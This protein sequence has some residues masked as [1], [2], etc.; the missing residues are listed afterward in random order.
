MLKELDLQ[1]EEQ[2]QSFMPPHGQGFALGK[3][4][5]VLCPIFRVVLYLSACI[6]NMVNNPLR[7]L[8]CVYW[9]RA[10]SHPG[11]RKLNYKHNYLKIVYISL[12]HTDK[13]LKQ[14]KRYC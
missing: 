2:K 8:S 11:P 1:F 13:Q 6:E 7:Q 5:E 12:F 3:R 10:L 4:V 14:F 9:Q